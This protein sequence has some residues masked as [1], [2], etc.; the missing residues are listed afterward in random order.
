MHHTKEK[1][2]LGVLKAQLDL[3]NKGFTVCTPLTE[4]APFDLVVCKDGTCK[5]IQVK[6]R[7]LDRYGKFNVRFSNNHS[8]SNGTH[9]K[10]VNKEL[11]DFYCVYCPETDLCYY[12]DPNKFNK[13]VSFRVIKSKNNQ[14]QNINSAED[15]LEL[16]Y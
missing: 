16:K 6:H 1:G 3:F 10:E 5:T 15:Y 9:T 4:H 13:H 14:S 8:D 12:F 11:I 2:D 7:H